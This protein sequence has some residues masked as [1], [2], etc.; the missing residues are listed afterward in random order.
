MDRP[1]AAQA[2]HVSR[3]RG[4]ELGHAEAMGRAGR[5]AA[6]LAEQQLRAAARG[7]QLRGRGAREFGVG[8]G[9][10][11]RRRRALQLARCGLRKRGSLGSFHGAHHGRRDALAACER[12]QGGDQRAI[13]AA[14]RRARSPCAVGFGAWRFAAVRRERRPARERR[15][16]RPRPAARLRRA[17]EPHAAARRSLRARLRRPGRRRRARPRARSRRPGRSGSRG[18]R[19]RGLQRGPVDQQPEV[20]RMQRAEPAARLRERRGL[21]GRAR[22]PGPTAD[23]RCPR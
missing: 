23:R 13:G 16:G 5:I 11:R 6:E 18:L 22:L 20:A 15:A 14:A 4:D 3:Q 9:G 2:Q 8:G 7:L 17:R 10:Q 1:V 21:G 19:G 12:E